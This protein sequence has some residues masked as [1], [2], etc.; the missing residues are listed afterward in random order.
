MGVRMRS[1]L[2][3]VN[4]ILI[5]VLA[6]AALTVHAEQGQAITAPVSLLN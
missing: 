5:A 6:V 2:N 4:V 1:P 3:I